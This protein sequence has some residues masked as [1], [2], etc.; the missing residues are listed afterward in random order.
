MPT[1]TYEAMRDY[2]TWY[3][4]LRYAP[5]NHCVIQSSDQQ[6][7]ATIEA[8]LTAGI[9][10]NYCSLT[11][12]PASYDV[13]SDISLM[14]NTTASSAHWG[15]NANGTCF[16]KMN[17][18]K[19]AY[20]CSAGNKAE[21]CPNADSSSSSS[22]GSDVTKFGYAMDAISA[23]WPVHMGVYTNYTTYQLEWVTG[24]SG[25]VRWMLGGEPLFEIPA[26]A[27]EN[28]PQDAAQLNPK[29]IMLEEP[30]YI[31]FN[32]A[33]SSSWGA[34]P[35]NAGGACGGGSGSSA[36]AICDAFPL[37][38]KMD[39]IRL[40]QDQTSMAYGCDPTSHPTAQWIEDHIDEYTDDDNPYTV[41]LGGAFCTSDDDC[42]ITHE[43]GGSV[44]T[45]TCSSGRCKRKSSSWKGP[46]CVTTGASSSTNSTASD[47]GSSTDTSYGPSFQVALSTAGVLIVVM[48][49]SVNLASH[50]VVQPKAEPSQWAAAAQPKSMAAIRTSSD[51][52]F[53]S[54]PKEMGNYSTNFI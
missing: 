27:I 1:A 17:G 15:I 20:L 45:G 2:K 51:A 43:V 21:H 42:T 41:V 36:A 44:V 29:K 38:L 33:L 12:C 47:S 14:D 48:V 10:D 50:A 24:S 16:P 39:Y 6:T 28:P 4:G 32:V 31:I 40:Y 5:N 23:Y 37:Y 52:G 8:S 7:Y 9:T 49:V 46:R 54:V 18:Y 34:S 13:N 53:K 35:P 19:G 25:Y 30:M 3:Q 22:S 11:T 26:S